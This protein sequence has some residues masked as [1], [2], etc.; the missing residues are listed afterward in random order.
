MIDETK[1]RLKDIV[2]AL[3][4]SGAVRKARKAAPET[5]AACRYWQPRRRHG[6][7]QNPSSK[8]CGCFLS[9]HFACDE[10]ERQHSGGGR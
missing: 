7:C 3:K 5:C 4:A 8:N 2:I 6:L 9:P 10:F 1:M